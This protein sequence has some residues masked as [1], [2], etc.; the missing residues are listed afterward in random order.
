MKIKSKLL[1]GLVSATII[2]VAIVSTVMVMNLRAQ[3]VGDFIERSH[4]E[5]SQ[6]DNAIAIYFSGIEQNVKMLANSPSLQKVDSSITQYID[7]QSVTMTPDQNGIVERGIYQQLD[8]MGKSHKGYAYVY[9]GTREGG[10]IQ[11][12]TGKASNNYDPRVRPWYKTAMSN[13]GEIKRTQAYYWEPDDATI[14]SNVLSFNTSTTQNAGVVAIDVSLKTLTDIVKEIKLGETG[15][16]M[17]IEDSGNVL[18]DAK[19]PNNNFK[20][21]NS[22]ASAYKTIGQTSS[23]FIDVQIDGVEYMA[24]VLP[25]EKLGWKFVGLITA[26]EVMAESNNLIKYILAIVFVLAVIFII[27]ALFLA[28]LIAKPLSLVSKG[29]QEIAEGEGD[30]TK[31][32]AIRSNDETGQL[33][34]YFNAFLKAIRQLVQQIGQAGEQMGE[35]AQRAAT[36]SEDLL[37]VSQR[38]NQAVEM[39]STAFNEMVATANEVATLCSSAAQAAN[40]SQQLV[41]EGQQNIHTAVSSVNQ[42]ADYISASSIT[43]EELEGDSQG[44]T[45]ILDTIRGIA[46]QTNLLALNAAIEAARAGDQGRGFAVVADEVRALAKRTQDSTEEINGLVVRLQNRTKEVAEQMTIS[47]NASQ[48]TVITTESVNESFSG[49]YQSVSAIHDMNTQI[50]TAAEEQHL[51]AEEINRNIQ[52]VHEDTQK[53]DDVSSRAQLNSQSLASSAV[54]LNNLVSKFK[55]H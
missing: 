53:V 1:L 49:I 9:M 5:M 45:V 20:A 41:S 44:I 33:A 12:P 52:Q 21:L 23:G 11:W 36:I 15:Y 25:S 47:L 16:I 2:P 54:D 37:A 50:A 24:N 8:L 46:E 30:L 55:T 51:V 14:V 40:D 7:K 10:Y 22:L 27:G 29:L 48:K 42:L 13:P 28:G 19:N 17:M 39:V 18:V 38:Q 32:L 43:I 34:G 3:A 26:E 4:G 35:S 31:E 6:V